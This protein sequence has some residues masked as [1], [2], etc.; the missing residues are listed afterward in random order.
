MSRGVPQRKASSVFFRVFLAR[1]VPLPFNR[2]KHSCQSEQLR[3]PGL[4]LDARPPPGA[5]AGA[6]ATAQG[7]GSS[8]G[9]PAA[10]TTD[11]WTLL[12]ARRHGRSGAQPEGGLHP[13]PSPPV[14][15][16]EAGRGTAPR[17]GSRRTRTVPLPAG[18]AGCTRL[19]GRRPLIAARAQAPT[20]GAALAAAAAPGAALLLCCC[21]FARS[22][23]R[24]DPQVA[25]SVGQ[26]GTAPPAQRAP[27]GPGIVKQHG[28]GACLASREALTAARPVAHQ[29]RRPGRRDWGAAGR[30]RRERRRQRRRRRARDPAWAVHGGSALP[31]HAVCTTAE[32]FEHRVSMRAA[33]V[34]ANAG[35]IWRGNT[36]RDPDYIPATRFTVP[37]QQARPG[38]TRQ[39]RGGSRS[40]A[41]L[42]P[43]ACSPAPAPARL[44]PCRPQQC[45]SFP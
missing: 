32:R 40:A 9:L 25:A 43:C 33:S 14:P 7:G 42:Q 41:R 39:S 24:C 23:Q 22:M 10:A 37:E 20:A 36:R 19:R 30:R 6:A 4:G 11:P 1:P 2:K 28:T 26:P 8:C 15:R 44:H 18:M 21:P 12:T 29:W 5:R 45:P 31:V 34:A 35:R 3:R 17:G 16:A 27:G 38:Q 13:R